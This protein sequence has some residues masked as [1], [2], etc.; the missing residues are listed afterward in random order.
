MTSKNKE[1]WITNLSKVDVSLAD[2]NVTIRSFA[3]VNLLDSRHYSIT[4]TQ[5]NASI[6]SG[7]IY[8][9]RDK[10]RV[11]VAAPPPAPAITILQ[12]ETSLP[13]RAR[14]GIPKLVPLYEEY[15]VS[16]EQ[17]AEELAETAEQDRKPRHSRNQ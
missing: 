3:S 5:A 11:R 7:S 13:S 14:S 2:L 15:N 1:L 12:Q 16:D 4:E 6:K 10:I 9:K 8:K 17:Y